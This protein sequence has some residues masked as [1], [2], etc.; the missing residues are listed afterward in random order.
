V[1]F[2]SCEEEGGPPELMAT[3]FARTTKGGGRDLAVLCSWEGSGPVGEPD[4]L[5]RS[6]LPTHAEGR[7]IRRGARD[8]AERKARNE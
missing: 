2:P 8:G 7:K 3:F 1:T 6:L 4:V 5:Q